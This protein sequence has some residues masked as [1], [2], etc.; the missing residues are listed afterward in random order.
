MAK[1]DTMIA[2]TKK[3]IS[4]EIAKKLAQHFTISSL[5]K[6]GLDDICKLRFKKKDA[7]D[8]LN[9]VGIMA[10]TAKAKKGRKEVINKFSKIKG[11]GPSKAEALYEAGFRSMLELKL[12]PIETIAKVKGVGKKYAT[13]IKNYLTPSR[14][15]A[16]KEFS[17]IKGI[18]PSKA[19]KLLDA[20]Y[21]SKLDMKLASE[22][23]LKSIIGSAASKIKKD[24][25]SIDVRGILA[26]AENVPPPTIEEPEKNETLRKEIHTILE[27]SG[28]FL[29]RSITDGII[30]K[31][32][33]KDLPK[34]KLEY[35]V[36]KVVDDYTSVLMDPLEACGIVAAQSIGEPG[37]Q[38]TMRTFHY[39]G[40]AEINVTLGLP[41][42][43]EIVDARKKP[44][45]PMMTVY[46]EGACKINRDMA[47]K[48]ANKI[49]ITRLINV[50][51]VNT[52]L[53]NMMIV[54]K[55]N[56]KAIER[57]N[58][59]I[60][61]IEKRLKSLR[62]T[63][64][65]QT[66]DVIEVAPTGEETYRE[67]QRINEE[68]KNIKIKGIDGIKRAIIR[69]EK[70]EYIIY[71][72]GSNFEK[73]LAIEGVDK[74]RTTTNDIYAIYTVLGVE[75]ARNA[76]IHE[77]Y[78]TLQEQ[79]LNV[80]IRHIM[81]VADTMTADGTIRS[82]GRQGISGEKSSVIA[83]AAFEITVNHLL[84]AAKRGEIDELRGVAENIIVGQP[85]KLGTGSVELSVDVSKMGK[86]E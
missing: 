53:G 17:K 76:I 19:E 51:E 3:G 54:V 24:L 78:N 64:I 32:V 81:L 25:G 16:L 28:E 31:V 26:K 40:V 84:R 73:V 52:D 56:K 4:K 11:I 21:R 29:P 55:P 22:R 30:E 8:I 74:T 70:G 9:K 42:L 36:N 43:I 6:A 41:R 48:I 68:I 45:T 58:I 7:Q 46:L 66:G 63:K 2:L 72:E 61:D 44:S 35:L 27:S 39:A 12:Q 37:T 10:K 5:K 59:T 15:E 67:L 65:R 49:E 20:G 14:E 86:G 60:D 85:I 34:K 69:K 57:K 47:K 80:D 75:A 23:E 83:R 50:A 38:M 82:I 1:K 62:R 77:A 18:G 13:I 33:D 79:G 71:T